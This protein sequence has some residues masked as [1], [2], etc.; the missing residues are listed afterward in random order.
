[1]KA[2]A[3]DMYPIVYRIDM[4]RPDAY[5][6]G[7]TFP[8]RNKDVVYLARHPTADLLRF[9]ATVAGTAGQAAGVARNIQL[10]ESNLSAG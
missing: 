4:L 7:Q 9:M 8:I 6:I 10:M 5:L 3:Q 1:M 2:N